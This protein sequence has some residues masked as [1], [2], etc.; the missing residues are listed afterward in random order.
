MMNETHGIGDK[1]I[2]FLKQ[3][4]NNNDRPWFLEHKKEYQAARVDFVDFVQNLTVGIMLFD[5]SVKTT[6]DYGENGYKLFRI[7]RDVRF[8][9]NKNP[10]K[11]NFGASIGVNPRQVHAPMYYLHIEPGNSFL[12]GGIY[13]PERDYLNAIREDIAQDSST[14]RSILKKKDFK[15]NFGEIETTHTLKT[16]PRGYPKDHPDA[17]LLR[18]KSYIVRQKI[19]E[20]SVAQESFLHTVLSQYK[21][22]YPLVDYLNTIAQRTEVK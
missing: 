20:K 9:K 8:S 18:L 4:K 2:P 10:Y 1:V 11:E 6:I 14:L 5:A 12:A 16:M 19:D 17:D 3:I 15:K 21:V 13:M 7:N 22:I